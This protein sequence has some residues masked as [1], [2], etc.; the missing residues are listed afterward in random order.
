MR[1]CT[2]CFRLL[3]TWGD[4]HIRLYDFLIGIGVH[5]LQLMVIREK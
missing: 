4:M 1:S 5:C 2:F 3:R